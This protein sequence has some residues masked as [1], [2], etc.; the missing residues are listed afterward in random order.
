MIRRL[1]MER[2]SFLIRENQLRNATVTMNP[3]PDKAGRGET[4]TH[5]CGQLDYA[6]ANKA[7]GGVPEQH[8]EARHYARIHSRSNCAA[9]LS[10]LP[11][12]IRQNIRRQLRHAKAWRLTASV[13][14]PAGFISQSQRPKTEELLPEHREISR[15]FVAS[16][17]QNGCQ[18]AILVAGHDSCPLNT[19]E[20]ASRRMWLTSDISQADSH[21]C[22]SGGPP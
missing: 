13:V 1:L 17:G 5:L 14:G 20:K 8:F 2:H 19:L 11:A 18:H 22:R 12:T 21:H 4:V 15:N 9:L 10:P 16:S 7:R 6:G 3:V